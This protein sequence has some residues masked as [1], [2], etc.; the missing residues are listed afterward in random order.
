MWNKTKDGLYW[1]KNCIHCQGEGYIHRGTLKMLEDNQKF[2]KADCPKCT[3][4]KVLEKVSIENTRELEHY[5]SSEK[6]MEA[7]KNFEDQC[8]LEKEIL[9][10]LEVEKPK[11]GDQKVI[12]QDLAFGMDSWKLFE[13]AQVLLK[14]Y[15]YTNNQ[16]TKL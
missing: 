14:S 11:D 9:S 12:A 5:G 8:N 1:E 2:K 16:I 6:L 15:T 3:E 13:E 10:A 7:V 4:G